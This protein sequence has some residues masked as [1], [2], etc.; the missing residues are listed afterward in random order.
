MS[1]YLFSKSKYISKTPDETRNLAM[2]LS[3]VLDG[4]E[5]IL[6]FG[7]LGAGKTLFLQGL[8]QGLGVKDVVNSPTFNILKIYTIKNKKNIK[9]F[10]HIDAYRLSSGKDLET[11]GIKEIWEDK[12][13]VTAIEWAEKIKDI[14]PKKNYIKI[15]IKSISESKREI[16]IIKKTK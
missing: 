11:L 4:G 16:K 8:A 2:S 9:K 13:I 1:K 6:L 15:F 12:K 3:K 10:C 14:F 7:D 5:V